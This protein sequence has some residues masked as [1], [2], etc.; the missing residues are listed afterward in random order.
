MISL[1]LTPPFFHRGIMNPKRKP[2]RKP[3]APDDAQWAL[4]IMEQLTGMKPEKGVL[5]ALLKRQAKEGLK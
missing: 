5:A 3:R 2:Q 1:A 4:R